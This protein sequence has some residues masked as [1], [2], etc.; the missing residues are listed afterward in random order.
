MIVNV[1]VVEG[2][3]GSVAAGVV[4]ARMRD[5]SALSAINSAIL[6]VITKLWGQKFS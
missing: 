4:L 5:Y 6:A 3:T 2:N 1:D